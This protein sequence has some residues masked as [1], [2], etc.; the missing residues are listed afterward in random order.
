VLS[1]IWVIQEVM[2]GKWGVDLGKEVASKNVDV[3]ITERRTIYSQYLE[4][5]VQWLATYP[6]IRHESEYK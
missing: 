5:P 1:N 4:Y 2:A 6:M 3:D